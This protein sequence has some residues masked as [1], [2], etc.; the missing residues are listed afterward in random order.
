MLS[1]IKAFV[2]TLTVVSIVGMTLG[3]NQKET[4]APTISA[5]ALQEVVAPG[6]TFEVEIAVEN[7]SDL[8]VVQFK[9]VTDGGQ[10]GAMTIEDIVI[11]D[12]H[13]NFA[14]RTAQILA[15]VDHALE[16]AGVIQMTG[17]QDIAESAYLATVTVRASKDAAGVFRVNLDEGGE[18]FL[19]DSHAVP[20]DVAVRNASTVRVA[21]IAQPT[22]A[23]RKT[24]R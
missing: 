14:F 18:T 7:V 22:E 23:N 11:D 5:K 13:P 9:M 15:V 3:A 10:S 17:G 2:R 19:R 8:A 21:D 6:E 16:R 4:A 24:R 20:I 1:T 12:R